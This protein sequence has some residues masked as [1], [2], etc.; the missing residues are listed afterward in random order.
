M[1]FIIP[2]CAMPMMN[3]QNTDDMKR[4]KMCKERC[5]KKHI[6]DI[7]FIRADGKVE[8]YKINVVSIEDRVACECV[9]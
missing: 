3:L 5:N 8:T 1:L 2:S 4:A 6:P 7:K 9:F